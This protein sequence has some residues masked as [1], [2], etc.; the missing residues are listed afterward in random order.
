MYTENPQNSQNALS[1]SQAIY[2]Y[3][4]TQLLHTDTQGMGMGMAQSIFQLLCSHSAAR[5]C[6]A[7][8]MYFLRN[9]AA[10][11][12]LNTNLN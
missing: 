10:Q 3:M 8:K 4:Y 6:S 5:F 1:V 11:C 7:A 9:N 2:T 12:L